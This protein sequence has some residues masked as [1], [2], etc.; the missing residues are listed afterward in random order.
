MRVESQFFQINDTYRVRFVFHPGPPS[1][2]NSEW[3]PEPPQWLLTE[4]W[5]RYQAALM[6]FLPEARD[7]WA[8]QNR[9][10]AD[11]H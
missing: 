10:L 11:S 5:R 2:I 1:V 6:D 7:A 4:H 3:I 8:K 9:T